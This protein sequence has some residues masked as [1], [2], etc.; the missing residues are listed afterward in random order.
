MSFWGHLEALRWVILRGVIALFLCLVACFI[1]MPYLFD[2][3]VLAPTSSDFFLYRCLSGIKGDGV[4]IPDFSSDSYRV[5]LINIRV[6][7][8]FMTHVTTSFWFAVILV[9]PYLIYQLWT[10]IKPALYNN[11]RHNVSIA[12]A[13]GTFMFYLGCAVGYCIVFP[14]TFRF[15]SQYQISE[16]IVNQ[17]SLDSYMSTFLMLIL[18][19]GVVFELPLL[20]WLLGHLGVINKRFLKQYRRHAV[21]VLLILAAVITPTSDPFTLMMVFLPLY[22]LYELSIRIVKDADPSE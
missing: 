18:V 11:E 13:G 8:Q 6:A 21:V 16:T 12:F 7:S 4:W 20:A 3:F 9:F 17:I 22:M 14:F 19:M 2:H 1:A 10:F 15:L 5:D